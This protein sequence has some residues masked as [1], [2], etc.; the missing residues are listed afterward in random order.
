[1]LKVGANCV[2]ERVNSFKSVF[3]SL[4][5]ALQNEFGGERQPDA[6][7]DVNIDWDTVRAFYAEEPLPPGWFAD[8]GRFM[9]WNGNV[10]D[11]RPDKAELLARYAAEHK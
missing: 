6:Q 4:L 8:C 7:K 1:M 11:D 10:S 2:P 3:F 9:D 5:L